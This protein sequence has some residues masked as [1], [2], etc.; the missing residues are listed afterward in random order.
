V[1]SNPLRYWIIY[2]I[3][4][5]FSVYIGVI[6]SAVAYDWFDGKGIVLS[7]DP[8]RLQAWVLY[9]LCNYGLAIIVVLLLRWAVSSLGGGV[10]P[11]HLI[12]YC[13]TFV[14]ACVVGPAGLAVAVHFFGQGQLYGMAYSDLYVRMLRWGLGP[15]LVSVYISYYLD[16]QACSDLPDIDRSAASVRWRLLNCFMFATGTVF[17]LLPN[18]MSLTAPPDATWVASKLQF[19]ATAT[20][21]C[22]AFGLALAA[23]FAL[24]KEAQ[25]QGP[26]PEAIRTS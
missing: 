16:R 3:A 10:N 19:V 17:L 6:V 4:L 1:Q 8:E 9:S 18:L 25:R 11:S 21:F 26:V 7:Q 20:T 23:Q 13:W 14:V 2:A 5:I 15:A 22:V 12:T 24:K